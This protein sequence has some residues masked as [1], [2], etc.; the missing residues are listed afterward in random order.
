MSDKRIIKLKRRLNNYS[1]T[2]RK[3]VVV[4]LIVFT[5][6]SCTSDFINDSFFSSK[7]EKFTVDKAREYFETF[8]TV[9]N[10][11][12]ITERNENG[13]SSASESRSINK[14]RKKIIT[15]TYIISHVRPNKDYS[16][17]G[18]ISSDSCKI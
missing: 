3:W 6:I 16:Y 18:L 1:H 10:V 4:I 8:A 11:P 2:S 17:E 13:V 14:E 15:S 5:I 9:L 7:E 12:N